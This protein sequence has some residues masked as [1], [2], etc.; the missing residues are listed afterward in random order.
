M[1]SLLHQTYRNQFLPLNEKQRHNLIRDVLK[2]RSI[3]RR[4]NKST[5]LFG[6]PKKFTTLEV[7]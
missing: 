6:I 3:A 4:Q 7:M 2:N 5:V 1:G